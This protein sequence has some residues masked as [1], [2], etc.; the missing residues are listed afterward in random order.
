MEAC[1][2]VT[3]AGVAANGIKCLEL[4]D[5]HDVDVAFLDIEMP[6]L[7]GLEVAELALDAETPPLIVFI[8]GHDEY[9]VQAFDLAAVDYVVKTDDL[10]VFEERVNTTLARIEQQL[11]GKRPDYELLR[12]GIM[13]LLQQELRPLSHK[14]PVKDYEEG[15][16][17]LLDPKTVIYVTR[18]GRQVVLHTAEKDFPTYFTI[19]KLAE[20]L[21]GAG[22]LRANRGEIINLRLV[23]H[24]IPNGDGSYDAILQD[25][26]GNII[27]TITVSRGRSKALLESLGM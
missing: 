6:E 14:L 5:Q 24:L 11:A 3:V 2:K 20:R 23:E 15:T 8:T 25:N 27:T 19:T 1:G 26:K 13:Q 21:T 12:K 9:A 4:L 18:E 22:F 7:S 16:V 10:D 17:R